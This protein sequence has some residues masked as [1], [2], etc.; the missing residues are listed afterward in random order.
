[1]ENHFLPFLWVHG[2]SEDRYRQ[3]IGVIQNA[4]IGAFC[5]EARPHQQ[6]CEERW[7]QDMT[8]ILD[9]AEKRG[10]KVWILDDKHFPTGFAAGQLEEKPVSLRRR[11]LTHRSLKVRAGQTVRFDAL[12]KAV[13]REHYGI[14]GTALMLVYAEGGLK[15]LTEKLGED[16]LLCCTAFSAAGERL[17][18][19]P[20]IRDNKLS[21]TVP[22]G[23]WT[24]ECVGVT[25]NSGIHRNYINMLDAESCRVQIE[26][27]YQP[28]YDHFADKFGTVIAGFFSDEPEL[29]NGNYTK[30]YNLLGT[31]QA[32]PY[33]EMLGHALAE[34]LGP[35][36]KQLL[37]LLWSNAFDSD[38]TARVRYLYMDAVTRLVSDCFSKQIGLW[39]RE[40][41]VEYIG[42]I[43]EDNNQHART[44]NSLG[45]YFRGL[46]WQSM[47]GIDD[48]GGQVQP[49]GEN[50]WKKN[51]FGNMDDG[52]FYHFALGKL[53]SSLGAL[54]P[55]MRG[56]TMCEI[57]GNYGWA[58]GVRLEKYLLDHFM[59]RGVNYFVPHAF[60]CKDF[61]DPDCPPH[62]YAQGHNPQY[63]HF[64]V[65]MQYG[66]RV[67]NLISGG[68]IKNE[69]AVLYHGEAE[70]TGKCMMMQKPGRVLAEHQVDFVYLP[71]DVFAERDFYQTEITDVLTVNGQTQK[72]VIV[73]YAEYL[74]HEAAEGLGEL[75]QKGGHVVFIDALPRGIATG[76]ALPEA[77]RRAMV[78]TLDRLMD[79]VCEFGL[80]DAVIAPASK[81]IR[82]LHYEGA[83]NLY[84]VSNEGETSYHGAI[85]L[86]FEKCLAYDAW[87]N[88]AWT[89]EVTES[90]I[91]LDLNPYESVIIL[92]GDEPVF[93]CRRLDESR[94]E[95]LK[96]A[97]KQSL[98]SFKLSVCKAEDY[99][100]FADK[101][102]IE[103]LEDYA[104]TDKKFSGILHYETRISVLAGVK[105]YLEI[106]D[107]YEGTEVFINGVS[108]GIQATPRTLW[109]LT[110]YCKSGE[111]TLSIEVATTL[112]RSQGNLK[113]KTGI[114][115]E[116]VLYKSRS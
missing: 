96:T 79:T 18:L 25:C 89:P 19:T 53:G 77:L 100:C 83:R 85:R 107:A 8:V 114:V 64:G 87:N 27:V 81:D 55:N 93:A 36:W 35:D 16:E 21:W 9:E 90:G 20:Y 86:P 63:R 106:T 30:Q 111:N 41:G 95:A 70:W 69:I 29:G 22:A 6:F 116:V 101:G 74:T 43:I 108:L 58:E 54:N 113:A 72:L 104:R 92:E 44:G 32:L 60:T 78:T 110:P 105:T 38:E 23:T 26:A 71:S 47:A 80:T 103:K 112:A 66:Q 45:H 84:L 28:H 75:M 5:V 4:N 102:S 40:H 97:R 3:M 11:A 73:P 37:P 68:K 115:G 15:M 39:C 98:T 2:E 67:T 14:V 48:I 31:D 61:P 7:W 88:E 51:F 24:I 57:F 94:N 65:L 1:M 50:I 91:A 12:K 34:A 56:R 52:E 46:K 33:S 17:D 59:V 49:G 10:M 76:E 99:P 62:F 13:P 42:H 109:E 82:A